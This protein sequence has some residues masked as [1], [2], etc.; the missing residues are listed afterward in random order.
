MMQ[1]PP[2]PY[3][4]GP[5]P[6]PLPP[7]RGCSPVL[8]AVVAVALGGV[9]AVAA[10]LQRREI[11]EFGPVTAACAGAAVAGTR[12]Y[13]PGQPH[14]FVGA[15][16]GVSGWTPDFSRLPS[17]R[18]AADASNADVVLCFGD[19]ATQTLETCTYEVSFRGRTSTY[20]YPRTVTRLP[21]RLIAASTGQPIAQDTVQ[22]VV[23][24]T[25]DSQ[26]GSASASP[27]ALYVQGP[28]VGVA[29]LQAWLQSPAALP[30]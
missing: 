6:V 4:Y 2:P 8:V 23:P 26:G 24:P 16:M 19:E 22:G 20:Q 30:R 9:V 7:R 13:V 11:A 14:R 27:S 21:V 28:S 18:R 17:E 1:A 3:G 12:P 10:V 15:R 29:E 5:M 25:C